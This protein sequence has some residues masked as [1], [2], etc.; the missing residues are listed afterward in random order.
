VGFQ[1]AL[2]TLLVVG[3]GLFLRTL[4]SLNAVDVGFRTDHLLLAEVNPPKKQYPAGKDVALHT[5]I[6]E[7]FAANPGVEA[8]SP[9]WIAYIADDVSR[10]ILSSRER[11]SR[12][13]RTMRKTFNVVGDKLLLP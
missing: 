11:P 3:A 2:S 4:A 7:R 13:T 5:R 6:L 12:K 8:V 9:A 10:P 1:I